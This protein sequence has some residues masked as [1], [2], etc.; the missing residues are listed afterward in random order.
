M[1]EQVAK[2]AAYRKRVT[3]NSYEYAQWLGA[4]DQSADHP[5]Q[6]IEDSYARWLRREHYAFAMMDWHIG[7]LLIKRGSTHKSALTKRA[8]RLHGDIDAS[9]KRKARELAYHLYG[10]RLTWDEA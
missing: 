7:T 5:T 2:A 3:A 9:W 10:I 1:R 8:K 6:E 4:E